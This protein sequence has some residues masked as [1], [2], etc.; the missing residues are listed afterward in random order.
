MLRKEMIAS[1]GK[2]TQN[3]LGLVPTPTCP[4]EDS[5]IKT[6]LPLGNVYHMACGSGGNMLST[7]KHLFNLPMTL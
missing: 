6:I 3:P 5:K 1:K 4:N 2:M 7:F